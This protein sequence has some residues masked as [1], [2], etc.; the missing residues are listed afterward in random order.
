M[1][2]CG[3]DMHVKRHLGLVGRFNLF[4]PI[5]GW[6]VLGRFAFLDFPIISVRERWQVFANQAK[7]F[8]REFL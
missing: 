5:A 4:W 3:A 6:G 2:A 7:Y 1:A 8:L